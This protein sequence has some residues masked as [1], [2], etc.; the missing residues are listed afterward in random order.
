MFRSENRLLMISTVLLLLVA[1]A[2]TSGVFSEPPDDPATRAVLDA[3]RGYTL[4][5]G[6]GMRPSL[7]DIQ[8]SL[9]LTMTLFL[10]FMVAVQ[11]VAMTATE[12]G[13]PVRSRLIL[14]TTL[15]NWALVALYAIYRVP[16]PLI[17]FVVT[18]V[19]LTWA[20]LGERK[21][22]RP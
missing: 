16:P 2:H 10:L 11:V 17:S 6:L 9:G 7:L 14:A 15:A 3:M 19:F 8:I 18:S 1:A 5:L 12:V 4:E 21:A 20:Y 13:S 22:G